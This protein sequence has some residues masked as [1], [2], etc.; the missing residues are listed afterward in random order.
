MTESIL[1]SIII[2][3]YNVEDY[4]TECLIS[5][6]NDS[7]VDYFNQIEVLLVNDKT[8][9]KSIERV[10]ALIEKYPHV[11]K[12]IN[13]K[14][15]LGLGGARNTGIKKAS[16]SFI[17]FLDSDDYYEKNFIQFFID[18][19]KTVSEDE[20]V[21][22]GL[23]ALNQSKTIWSYIPKNNEWI[24][25]SKVLEELS[26]DKLTASACNKIFPKKAFDGISFEENL[27]YEDLEFTPRLL[28]RVK[29]AHFINRTFLNYRLEGTSITRQETNKKHI[30]D[31]AKVLESLY[32]AIEN[33]NIFSNFFFD[34]WRHSLKIWSLSETLLYYTLD[35]IITLHSKYNL[36]LPSKKYHEFL[37]CFNVKYGSHSINSIRLNKK[38]EEFKDYF[39]IP[40]PFF[41][42]I[43]PLYNSELYI[44]NIIH[45]YSKQLFWNFELVLID[46]N[47]TDRTVEIIR[48]Y[49]KKYDFIKIIALKTNGGPGSSRNIGLK[50]ANGNYIIFN[51]ADDSFEKNGLEIIYSHLTENDFPD[52][53]IF[54]FNVFDENDNF[55]WGSSK[56]EELNIGRSTGKRLLKEIINTNINPS[57]WNKVF[58]REI[59]INNDI[60]FPEVIHHQDLSA[61]PYA[62]FKAKT[63][64]ILN[65]RL[66]NYKTNLS[67]ISQ[68]TS[69]KHA[70]S[71]F[72]AIEE[73]Y[74]FFIKDGTFKEWR[75]ELIKLAFINF[76]YN[77]KIRKERFSDDQII[78]YLNHFN[79]FVINN[80][81][82]PHEIIGSFD[83]S[84]CALSLIDE[85]LKRGIND[86][87]ITAHI[88]DLSLE[89]LLERSH[90]FFNQVNLLSKSA[91]KD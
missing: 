14:S 86:I 44:D 30:D 15:N 19:L 24:E 68:T 13:H 8:P 59:W 12:L 64:T 20:I 42:I 51:D 48:K 22:F 54:A 50:Y 69:D 70:Y 87:K 79:D 65:K 1:L 28:L 57:P 58:K 37:H 55:L 49:E 26:V 29:G 73:L 82:E 41:S 67:G 4:I 56:I 33:Q 25:S 31:M 81:I 83:A 76:N 27:Y 34:R 38:I 21:V 5:I 89:H 72:K 2:P 61:I 84:E 10:H 35:V 32:N 11:I 60:K 7:N 40:Y 63:A 80:K 88:N 77:L 75:E 45:S 74:I 46:D 91:K 18:Y 52:V 16:G 62:C 6:V 71:P 90:L 23:K 39:R 3:V 85:K 17:T 66:Y 47:S 36:K 9:D 43:I 53:T 78:I